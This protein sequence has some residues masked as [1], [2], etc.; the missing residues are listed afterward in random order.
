MTAGRAFTRCNWQP[1]DGTSNWLSLNN[2]ANARNKHPGGLASTLM[3]LFNDRPLR[4]SLKEA[5]CESDCCTDRCNDDINW[6]LL[7]P[8]SYFV[9]GL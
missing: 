6:F 9:M 5:S 3:M 2:T 7:G 8:S 1:K 4:S